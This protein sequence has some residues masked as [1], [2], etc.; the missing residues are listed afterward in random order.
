M[1]D[2][3]N[4][5]PKEIFSNQV[6]KEKKKVVDVSFSMRRNTRQPLEENSV[7]T[8]YNKLKEEM[9]NSKSSI[10]KGQIVVT[11]GTSL[12]EHGNE[13]VNT[14]PQY[15]SPYLIKNDFVSSTTYYADRIFTQ[16]YM[17]EYIANYVK[18]G[19]LGTLFTGV[20]QWADVKGRE[21][22]T[23][24]YSEIFN[25][26][27]NNVVRN[28]VKYAH[29]EGFGNIA[30]GDVAHVEGHKVE[31]AG[32]YSH[33]EGSYS[34]ASG[35]VAHAEGDH[36]NASGDYSHTQGTFTS[37]SQQ[38]ATAIGDHTVASGT[39]SLS[40]GKSTNAIGINSTTFGNLTKARAENSIAGGLN[41]EALAKNAIAI[42]NNTLASGENS[43][44]FGD[45][46][47]A[48][49]I[50]SHAEG[51]STASGMLSHSEGSSTTANGANA[52]AEGQSTI[53][54][55]VA[56][57]TE[58]I[59]TKAQGKSSHAEGNS[60]IAVG[61]NAHAE[62]NDS[63][64][65]NDNAHAEGLSTN[66]TAAQ[67]HSEGNSTKAQGANSHA[68]N[69]STTAI[70]DS[71]HTEGVS[72]TTT[73]NGTAGHAEGDHTTVSAIAAHAEGI[74]TLVDSG[75]DGSHTEG[76][77]ASTYASYSHAEGDST[78]ARGKGS[79]VEGLSSKTTADYAHAEGNKTIAAGVNSHAE[80]I[81]SEANGNNSH[82]EGDTNIA[83][84]ESSH[85]EGTKTHAEGAR[86]H[87]EGDG[88]TANGQA[89]H[90][91]G[92]ATIAGQAD[93]NKEMTSYNHAEGWKTIAGGNWA[94]SEGESTGAYGRAS[95]TQGQGSNAVG[96]YS[97]ATGFYSETFNSSETSLGCYNRSYT[98]SLLGSGTKITDIENT[99][100][101]LGG[102]YIP[103]R[104]P[105]ESGH[106]D[107]KYYFDNSYETLFTIGDGTSDGRTDNVNP[108]NMYDED[109]RE[110][111][112]GNINAGEY[113]QRT[114]R[115]NI[116]DIRK[117]G[118]MYYSGGMIVG[119]EIVGPASYSYVA[120][121]GPTAYFTTI[122][123]ALLTQPE[124]YRPYLQYIF[125]GDWKN[126]Q[127]GKE[128]HVEVGSTSKY[129]VQFYANRVAFNTP[130]H[131]DPIYG[132][133][134]G[135]MLGYSTGIKDIKYLYYD[136]N[137]KLPSKQTVSNLTEVNL[138][139]PFTTSSG[140]DYEGYLAGKVNLGKELAGGKKDTFAYNYKTA[141]IYTGTY[142]S[143]DEV[144]VGLNCGTEDTY[145]IFKF[146]SYTF[147]GAS[148]M[149]FQQLADKGTYIG[150]AGQKPLEKFN[151]ETF[152]ATGTVV[153][154][155]YYKFYYGNSDLDYS[156]L[157]STFKNGQLPSGYKTGECTFQ[158]GV[159][160]TNE[161]SLGIGASGTMACWVAVPAGLYELTKYKSG[162]SGYM[163]Y[164]NA[165]NA[166]SALDT[167]LITD[168]VSS[169]RPLYDFITEKT[170]GACGLKYH[171]Y[172]VYVPKRLTQG[173][174]WFKIKRNTGHET[175]KPQTIP[176]A[177][178]INIKEI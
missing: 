140:G 168:S 32:T 162:Q 124:Y 65:T 138:T 118:Q 9:A 107:G 117:N 95:H 20:G 176:E 178:L 30:S 167:G 106:R 113:V 112:Q 68:E 136:A 122:M 141:N 50:S 163:W 52:H 7:V 76:Y 169:A 152:N 11:Q 132:T 22:A 59:L 85:A 105:S 102:K 73:I 135:N 87:A 164:R 96:V 28:D 86:A 120:S 108:L 153:V 109:G 166:E 155:A 94:H 49:G 3:T 111:P 150:A 93:E 125:N 48:S 100:A 71:S 84:G 63:H 123:A 72:T 67:S 165:M 127:D 134:L 77:K 13:V 142:S 34:K 66:A 144:T 98:S 80:G 46:S 171:V 64:A 175:D 137:K 173:T 159:G 5:D 128:I 62:G 40:T 2:I 70:A 21:Q 55:G 103:G 83:N 35:F 45:G 89:S 177:K 37:A 126:T 19:Q 27:S 129:S 90:A 114:G 42:G 23:S 57:H 75:A 10:Y 161:A 146:Q 121:L 160:S 130:Q 99:F 31:G 8:D 17:N 116:M 56:S 15:F 44:A 143:A 53:A 79:H 43:S 133:S 149:Y 154:K 41:S 115:H 4:R 91:E 131:L 145:T 92:Y 16:S 25:D 158:G 88:S 174:W 29:I 148:Q 38:A 61:D 47:T 110:N 69:F 1:A 54:S 156:A 18:K 78:Q 139:F 26:Y 39:N 60:S 97:S 51:S 36:T 147:A 58:G 81:S 157:E 14:S 119:G 170:I 151:E 24:T 172:I 12:D 101:Q 82:A 33:V 74:Q 104:I 6:N